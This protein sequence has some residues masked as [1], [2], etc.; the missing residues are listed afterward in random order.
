MGM[1]AAGPFFEADVNLTHPDGGNLPIN[2]WPL[3]NPRQTFCSL[4]GFWDSQP[5]TTR[6]NFGWLLQYG[7]ESTVSGVPH[8][9]SIIFSFGDA[10]LD[11]KVDNSTI[12]DFHS[13]L[14]AKTGVA[15]WSYTWSPTHTSGITF[16]VVY[17]LFISRSRPN[18]AAVRAEITP[19]A[20]ISGLVTDILDGRSA[21]RSVALRTGYDSDTPTIYSAVAPF[22]LPDIPAF[23]VSTAQF[24]ASGVDQSSRQRASNKPYI[25]SSDSTVAQSFTLNLRNGQTTTLYKYVGAASADGFPDPE[26]QARNSASTARTAGWD[27]LLNEHKDAW[28]KLLPAES[29]DDYSNP[30]GS[31]PE[32]ENIR[33]LQIIS[34]MTPYYLLQQTLSGDSGKGLGDNSI[35]VGGLTSDSYAG[36]V[37]WDA[38][39]FMSPGLVASHPEYARTIANYRIR[40][41]D[42]AKINALASGFS[43]GSVLFPWTSARFGN[44]TA[45]GPCKDYQYHINSDVAQMLLQHRNVTGDEQWWREKAWPIYNGVAQMFSELLQYNKTTGN[46][47]IYNMTDP[48]EYANGV[49]NGAFTL[50]SASKILSTANYFRQLYGMEINNTWADIARNVDI[51]YDN[52]GITVEYTGMNNSVPIKQA[53]V[54]LNTYPLD[55]IYNYTDRQKLMDLDYYANKQSPDGPAMTYSV[56][57]IIAN[58]VSPSGCS[59]YTYALNAFKSY[60]RAPWYLFS[61]QQVDDFFTNG[62]TN[63]AFPFLTG[64]GG[65]HQIGPY[66]WLGVRTTRQY[67]LIDPSLPPQI[68]HFRLRRFFYSGATLDVTMNQ[69]HTT[70]RRVQSTNGFVHDTYIGT[71]MPILVGSENSALHQLSVDDTLTLENRR[72]FAKLTEPG[73]L[74][75][76]LPATANERPQPG[77]F[78]L[79]AVDGATSTKWQPATPGKSS[80]VVDMSTVPYQPITAVRLDWGA[81]PPVRARV[82]LSNSSSFVGEVVVIPI[83]DIAI[84]VPVNINTDSIVKPFVGNT[85]SVSLVNSVWS[86]RYV[87]LE[88]EGTLGGESKVGATVAEFALIGS[89]RQDGQGTPPPPPPYGSTLSGVPNNGPSNPSGSAPYGSTLAGVP[90]SGS[91]NPSGS[92]P[93]GSTL[94]GVPDGGSSNPSGSALYGSTLEGSSQA[95]SSN[96]AAPYGSTLGRRWRW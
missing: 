36:F 74:L 28:S 76:C 41:A 44:C 45:T 15:T 10:Y 89:G 58:E 88:I 82:I 6:T 78:A 69:T 23:V 90:D 33:D 55:Y 65:F 67:L 32:D 22:G 95:S 73:N 51:P 64:H 19:S 77:Q 56:I 42:R 2:G 18:I 72:Y 52:S 63:P 40:L 13:S 75:Q 84:S 34:K 85:T 68:S 79:G 70:I 17:T 49:D 30:D 46:Y 93:Y 35:S 60:T 54:V 48:D 87:K 7:G 37:F 12:S 80:I 1:A 39:L 4:A 57:S 24:D 81:K 9:A 94:A 71:S 92:A 29:T 47:Q 59:A 14:S 16:K 62:G 96:N 50:A 26:N 20:D 86:G 83:E 5:N 27:A 91:S 25:S 8:W 66:G 21:V 31:L 43:D 3:D 11:A 61:E 38:D 53:D